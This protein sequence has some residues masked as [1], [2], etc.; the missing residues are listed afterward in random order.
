M[1]KIKVLVSDLL[2]MILAFFSALV[3]LITANQNYNVVFISVD[4]LRPD[5]LGA[6][7]YKQKT[8]PNIDNL[9][10]SSTV[11]SN[12]YSI[13]PSSVG[14]YYSLFTGNNYIVG[15]ELSVLKFIEDFDTKKNSE[16]TNLTTSFKK[17]GYNTFAFVSNPKLQKEIFKTGFDEFVLE[18]NDSLDMDKAIEKVKTSEKK[19]FFLWVDFNLGQ[20][21][22]NQVLFEEKLFNCPNDYWTEVDVEEKIK[23]YDQNISKIDSKIGKLVKYIKEAGLEKNTL[24]VIYSDKG[25]NFDPRYFGLSKTLY[26][27]DTKSVLIVKDPKKQEKETVKGLVDNSIVFNLLQSL[28]GKVQPQEFVEDKSVFARLS[29]GKNLK[30][31]VTNKKY[32]Y[33]YNLVTDGCLPEK[34]A[35]EFYDLIADP[36]EKD[37]LIDDPSKQET[38]KGMKEELAKASKVSL[39]KQDEKVDI[40]ERLKQLGY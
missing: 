20:K 11:F 7:G 16:Y 26:N 17:N 35:S 25:E 27:S 18:K 15:N 6:Y 24:I 23:E 8:S 4:S 34:D 29:Y 30:L 9:A 13:Y 12:F 40:L 14:S 19:S 33:I 37:N 10:E 28:T 38:I 2:L 21:D 3:L 31:A 32:K 1:R 36:E 22:D 39:L 5:H